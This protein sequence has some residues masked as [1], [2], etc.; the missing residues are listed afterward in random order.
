MTDKQQYKNALNEAL[1]HTSNDQLLKEL[2]ARVT[3][4]LISPEQ[5]LR[6]VVPS[7]YLAGSEKEK[8]KTR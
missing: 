8:G 2:K 6:E 1:K 7:D 4:Q 5:V 3:A